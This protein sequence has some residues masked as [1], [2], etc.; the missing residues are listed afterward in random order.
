MACWLLG[1]YRNVSLT[2]SLLVRY[3]RNSDLHVPKAAHVR[4]LKKDSIGL[5]DA[6]YACACS[7]IN[8]GGV[9]W[10]QNRCAAC[11]LLHPESLRVG[12]LT[13][14]ALYVPWRI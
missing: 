1:L 4:G 7:Q 12:S 10:G 6:H 8:K 9:R 13:R 14:F 2:A 3:A 5:T 11:A